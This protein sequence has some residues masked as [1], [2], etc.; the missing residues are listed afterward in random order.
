MKNKY[1]VKNFLDE[2]KKSSESRASSKKVDIE[3][4]HNELNDTDFEFVEFKV[5]NNELTETR[6]KPI[7]DLRKG[8]ATSLKN[9][10]VIDTA[11]IDKVVDTEF[12]KATAEAFS[13]AAR[14]HIRNALSTGRFY[15]IEPG[16]KNSSRT[17]LG[18]KHVDEK[19]VDTTK[20]VKKGDVYVTEP[21]GD[22]VKT[23]A[24]TE[25]VAKNKTGSHIRY[26]LDNKTSK[27][28]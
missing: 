3:L 22:T 6:T 11:D 7:E 20:I 8:I 13:N 5:K 27:K 21:T 12:N 4:A 18:T 16:D 10:G 2:T 25:I 26:K 1:D 28:K 24:H 23:E 9:A 19:V 17:I 14:M 15:T